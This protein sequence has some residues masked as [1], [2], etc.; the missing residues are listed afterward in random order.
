MKKKYAILLIAIALITTAC[1]KKNQD[2]NYNG[3]NPIKIALRDTLKLDIKSD[4]DVTLTSDNERDVAV[5]DGNSI[6][7]KNVGS[8]NVK[9]DNGYK[10]LTVPVTVDLF[11]EPSFNFGCSMSDIIND[12][13]EPDYSYGD[14]TIVYGNA[15]NNNNFVSYTCTQMNYF[16][17]D[18]AYYMSSVYIKK[19]V[20]FQLDKYL[21][22]H[23]V[24]DSIFTTDSIEYFMYHGKDD[25]H[26]KCDKIE[27]VN[28]WN[29]NCLFYYYR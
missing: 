20:D 2:L 13:G 26:L 15:N 27:G 14:S 25:I 11:I 10:N 24:F 3:A 18:G 4:Y 21:D 17:N 29:D 23:F 5:I 6:Y 9:M 7:G 22:D 19:L 12:F 1:N 8:A 28:D 16:F